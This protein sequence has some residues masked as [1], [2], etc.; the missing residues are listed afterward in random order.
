MTAR[1]GA[2]DREGTLKKAE[3]IGQVKMPQPV[4]YKILITLPRIEDKIGES[5]I[6][7]ADTTKKAEEVA[8]CLGFVL[9]LGELAYRDQDKF[10]NGPWCTEGQ[11]VIMRNYS[12]TRFMIDG[13]E[14]RLINDDQVEAVVDD[15][16][17]YTRA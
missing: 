4:G 1:L 2:I 3:E 17:G 12:G 15:P 5:G 10:P 16:R 14:F 8:S 9:K 11:F 7:L 13:Q 6:I